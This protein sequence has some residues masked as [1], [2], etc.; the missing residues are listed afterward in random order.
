MKILACLLLPLIFLCEAF[1]S[2]PTHLRCE[3]RKDPLGIDVANPRLAWNLETG[4]LKPERGVRQNAYQVL[5]ASTPELLD[6]DQGD[7]WD[8]GKVASGDSTQVPYQGKSLATAQTCYWKVRFWDQ[9]DQAVQWS[10]VALWTM[11]VMSSGDWKA[12]WIGAPDAKVSPGNARGYHAA[13]TSRSDD[14][15][16]VQVDLGRSQ[17]LASIR[18]HSLRHADMD[19]F[20]FPERFKI[21]AANDPDFKE[22]TLIADQTAAYTST[23]F[24][25]H[26]PGSAAYR[27]VVRLELQGEPAAK[28]PGGQ[29][30]S[31]SDG[32]VSVA[33]DGQVG[34]GP[35]GSAGTAAVTVP[36]A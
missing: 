29:I 16:W 8:S 25:C 32:Q 10:D 18:M 9:K 4:D 14:I 12:K 7:L 28:P 3:F 34:T 19:G 33:S 20:G 30:G 24:A 17:P 5:V 1:A 36:D 6:K 22:S 27:I 11:G 13:Q 31:D 35:N 26:P 23:L 21:E 15:K 2:V